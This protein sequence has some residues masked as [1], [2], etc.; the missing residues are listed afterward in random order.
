M[1]HGGDGWCPKLRDNIQEFFLYD[2]TKGLSPIENEYITMYQCLEA[3][4][5]I[6]WI[7][8]ITGEVYVEVRESM[9]QMK[10]FHNKRRE[11]DQKKAEM[12]AKWKHK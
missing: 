2:V 7:D 12:E 10:R 6:P 11:H 5:A 4:N 9:L 3:W 8:H 1:H